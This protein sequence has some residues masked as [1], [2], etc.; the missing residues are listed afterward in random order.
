LIWGLRAMLRIDDALGVGYGFAYL[1]ELRLV[2]TPN[3]GGFWRNWFTK[4]A[5]PGSPYTEPVIIELAEIRKA[6]ARFR[7]GGSRLVVEATDIQIELLVDGRSL[8]PW[9]RY[10]KANARNLLPTDKPVFRA[11]DRYSRQEVLATSKGFI[12]F[13]AIFLVY[14]GARVLEVI[15]NT[16]GDNL[17]GTQF[18]A[19]VVAIVA[20]LMAAFAWETR[21]R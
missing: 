4:N 8:G 18:I 7:L 9:E 14:L 2:W 15:Y 6:D 10:I 1:T 17:S 16:Q 3:I 11:R 20:L 13:L 21:R 19:A 12:V 5:A